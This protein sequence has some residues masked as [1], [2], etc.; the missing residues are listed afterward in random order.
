MKT[1]LILATLLIT[2]L[3]FAAAETK[4]YGPALGVNVNGSGAALGAFSPTFTSPNAFTTM[5]V[6]TVDD[7]GENTFF[8]VCVER[9]GVPNL[10]SRSDGDLQ[11][12]GFGSVTLTGFGTLPAGTKVTVFVY[13][14]GAAA[15]GNVGVG[16][17]GTVTAT[18]S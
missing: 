10:C 2:A 11:A 1:T 15:N 8:S 6:T 12:N 14:L 18:F 7:L 4:T 9:A 13:T 5:T 17:T 3:P 16:T